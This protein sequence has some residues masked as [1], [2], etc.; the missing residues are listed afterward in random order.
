M[1]F[2]PLGAVFNFVLKFLSVFTIVFGGIMMFYGSKSTWHMLVAILFVVIT[3]ALMMLYKVAAPA[4]ASEVQ[5]YGVFALSMCIAGLVAYCLKATIKSA[6]VPVMGGLGGGF[7]FMTIS[8][9]FGLHETGAKLASALIGG[10]LGVWLTTKFKDHIEITC[11]AFI[12]AYLIVTS[13]SELAAG[14]AVKPGY[15]PI[16]IA[17]LVATAALTAFGYWFQRKYVTQNQAVLDK[18]D[19]FKQD[20]DIP[21]APT[22]NSV[23]E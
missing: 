17:Y 11:T 8:A 15:D 2:G 19:V 23:Q 4:N 9:T 7:L 10:I 1:D 6:M 21:L 22:N 14:P 12:G 13:I 16:Q 20:A 5:V 18:D 3:I